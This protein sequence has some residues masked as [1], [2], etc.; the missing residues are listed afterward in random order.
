MQQT[1]AVS[2]LCTQQSFLLN[3][4]L[5][6]KCSVYFFLFYS[7]LQGHRILVKAQHGESIITDMRKVQKEGE[8]S[9]S[10]LWHQAACC[11]VNVTQKLAYYKNC[12]ASFKV[13]HSVL[14]LLYILNHTCLI[15]SSMSREGIRI[16]H[17]KMKL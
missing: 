11:A 8:T 15:L 7:I 9:C 10:S 1:T 14:T 2:K 4:G 16:C 3:M 6:K 17:E 13:L 12:I 5:Q